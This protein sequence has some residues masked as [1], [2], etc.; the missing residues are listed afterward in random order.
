[1][2]EPR[3]KVYLATGVNEK[4]LPRA[5]PYIRT[6]NHVCNIESLVVTLDFDVAPDYRQRYPSVRFV[7]LSS[8]QVQSPNSNSC[9]QHGGF[10]PALDFVAPDDILIFT[11]ADIQMQRPFR[12]E[13]MAF[14]RSF[15]AGEVGVGY[16]R[17]KDD[18]LCEEAGR[19]LP[20]VSIDE[21]RSQYPGIDKLKTYNTGVLVASRRTYEKLYGRYNECWADLEGLFG[22]YAKQ[23]WLLSYLIQTDFKPRILPDSIHTHGHFPVNLRVQGDAGYRFCL[24]TDPV[25]LNHAIRHPAEDE[26]H[27]LKRW[28]G[29]LRKRLRKMSVALAAIGALC[30]FLVVR[31]L[32]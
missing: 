21:L 26:V 19:L 30:V 10:L 23:Q 3:K 9:L 28:N 2:E 25:A 27:E 12:E 7:R 8:A 22:R 32:L 31:S 13:E 1:M 17:S 6:L 18:F 16:N 14:L 20:Q 4:Y 15:E 24:G 5:E 11:D 29:R